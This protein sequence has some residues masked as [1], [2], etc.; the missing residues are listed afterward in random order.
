MQ[1]WH[2]PVAKAFGTQI[3]SWS[4]ENIAIAKVELVTANVSY[5]LNNNYYFVN[6]WINSLK[7]YMLFLPPQIY[8]VYSI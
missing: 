5:L 7:I 3:R 4:F 2:F 1:V 6:A 8:N